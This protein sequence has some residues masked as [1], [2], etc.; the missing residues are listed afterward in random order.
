MK[1]YKSLVLFSILSL[2]ACAEA[3]QVAR[4]TLGPAPVLDGGS[5]S[6]GGGITVA[7]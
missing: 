3:P 2:A 7:A 5:Y 1:R 6:S 4:S